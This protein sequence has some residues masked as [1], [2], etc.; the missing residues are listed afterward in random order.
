MEDNN[1]AFYVHT[2]EE[3]C[4]G[5]L[6]KSPPENQFKSQKSWKKR[7]FVLLKYRDNTCQLKYYKNEEKDK[8]LGD[9]DL[10]KVTY[11]SLSPESHPMCKWIEKNFRCFAS[12]VMFIKVTERDYFLIGENSGEMDKWFTAL[13]D[14][15]NNHQHTLYPDLKK[16]EWGIPK[17][18]T[19]GLPSSVTHDPIYVTQ[20]KLKSK[21][22]H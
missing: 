7:F 12:C 1:Y 9:I 14:I 8:P 17:Y 18:D 4:S 11:V 16:T 2:T 20:I 21:L 15:L 5:Y 13:F 19:H 22:E 10:T 3:I 6:Y